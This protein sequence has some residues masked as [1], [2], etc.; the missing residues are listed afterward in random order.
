MK[1]AYVAGPYNAP[2]PAEHREKIEAAG[3]VAYTIAR[4][5]GGWWPVCVHTMARDWFGF[6]PEPKAI[7]GDI[8]L[9]KR[10]DAVVLTIGWQHSKGTR[11]EI[12]AAKEAGIPVYRY[13]EALCNSVDPQPHDEL[14]AEWDEYNDEEGIPF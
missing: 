9:L 1:I 3:D 6:V 5:I 4:T 11:K 14:L 7:Q 2:T 13:P 12:V 8:E 10:C